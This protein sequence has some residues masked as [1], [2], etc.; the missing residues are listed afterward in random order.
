MEPIT[1]HDGARL[2]VLECGQG[3][4]GYLD[5]TGRGDSVQVCV[6]PLEIPGLTV[7]LYKAAGQEPPV[8][9]GRPDVAVLRGHEGWVRL[10]GLR[11]RRAAGGGVEFAIGG[12]TETLPDAMTR[13]C[14]AVAVALADAEPEQDTAEVETLARAIHAGRCGLTAVSPDACDGCRAGARAALSAGWK[15]EHGNA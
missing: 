8:M 12:N 4:H 1:D 14:A 7:A 11:V 6:D 2:E 3:E 10:R 13:T 15:R 9:L 5:A